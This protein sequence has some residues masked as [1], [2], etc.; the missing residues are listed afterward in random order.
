MRILFWDIDGTLLKTAKAGLYAFD[1]VVQEM[2]HTPFDFS[3]IKT[4]GMTDYYIAHQV[5]KLANG[6]EPSAHE[7][8]NLIARYEEVLPAHLAARQGHLIPS[9]KDILTHLHRHDDYVSLLL[10]GNTFIGAKAKLIHY[11]LD[12]FFNFKHSA[13]CRN[14]FDRTEI[15]AQALTIVKK[16]YPAVTSEHIYVIGDTPNDI[17]CGKAI[18]A[19]TIAV[20]TGN[21]S[22]E[23]L[24]TYSPWWVV[25]ALP[26]PLEFVK[27][28]NR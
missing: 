4:A 17:H 9:V 21:Y 5:L 6:C 28:I 7:V 2:L 20:A 15:S 12:G 26:S 16:Y 22:V 14:C 10:T 24:S 23:E 18:A 3:A 1:Q 8:C 13:F 27:T 11:G 19:R 25:S